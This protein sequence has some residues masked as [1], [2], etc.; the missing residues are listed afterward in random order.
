MNRRTALKIGASLGVGITP[1]DGKIYKVATTPDVA[2]ELQ[3]KLGRIDTRRRGRMIRDL[4]FA[5][6]RSR[7]FPTSRG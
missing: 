3:E 7:G 4:T 1:D 5:Y 2:N 6:V